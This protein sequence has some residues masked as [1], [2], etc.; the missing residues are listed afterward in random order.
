VKYVMVSGARLREDGL[1]PL[2]WVQ[3]RTRDRALW[4]TDRGRGHRRLDWLRLSACLRGAG[5]QAGAPAG[6][7]MKK[8][9]KPK[10]PEMMTVYDGPP[11]T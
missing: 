7:E 6:G 10:L 9:A 2:A 3:R 4:R 5:A 1:P 11:N 8:D